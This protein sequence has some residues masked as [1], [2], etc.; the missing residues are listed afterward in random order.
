MPIN[1]VVEPASGQHPKRT[2]FIAPG[3]NSLL[4]HNHP[5]RYIFIFTSVHADAPCQNEKVSSGRI[6]DFKKTAFPIKQVAPVRQ[7]SLIDER[8][9]S[10]NAWLGVENSRRPGLL[11]GPSRQVTSPSGVIS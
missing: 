4:S 8:S 6:C 5:L 9:L 3:G 11:G 1:I 7:Q 2:I 10:L